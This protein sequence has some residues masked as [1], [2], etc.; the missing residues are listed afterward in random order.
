MSYATQADMIERFGERDLIALTNRPGSSASPPTIDEARLQSAL[1]DAEDL[2]NGYLGKRF[3]LPL[4]PL[5][6]LAV[7]WSCD[8][9]RWF[10]QPISAP[11][12]VKANYERTLEELKDAAAGELSL[13]VPENESG[14]WSGAAEISAPPRIFSSSHL[15]GF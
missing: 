10:L 15:K 11:E 4:N 8:L 6:S 3:S 14:S 1:K 9:A 13:G 2:I 7:R 12:Q 5:P